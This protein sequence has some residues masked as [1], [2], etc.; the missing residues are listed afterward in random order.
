MFKMAV[1]DFIAN[2]AA[3]RDAPLSQRSVA[4]SAQFAHAAWIAAS[5]CCPACTG[6][7]KLYSRGD[8]NDED[9]RG[10]VTRWRWQATD[11]FATGWFLTACLIW[12]ATPSCVKT[13][14]GCLHTRPQY[15]R[16][17]WYERDISEHVFPVSN[18]SPLIL[19]Q[20]LNACK[21]NSV[22]R[23]AVRYLVS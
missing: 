15:L 16:R 8:L 22:T 20:L 14:A 6:S 10:Q 13:R 3:T 9:N 1:T 11:P 19:W 18:N 7:H 5:R 21:K 23:Y 12:A 4:F 17:F 2:I